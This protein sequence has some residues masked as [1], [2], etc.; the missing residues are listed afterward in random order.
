MIKHKHYLLVIGIGNYTS[1]FLE[2]PYTLQLDVC[3]SSGL[4][5]KN[6]FKCFP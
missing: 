6:H 1:K 2:M 4:N 3:I 5:C